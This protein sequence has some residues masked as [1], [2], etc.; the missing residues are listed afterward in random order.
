[1]S[2]IIGRKQIILAALVVALGAAIFLNWRFSVTG[3]K[4]QAT[5]ANE[6]GTAQYVST[7]SSA[8]NATDYFAQARLNR[9]KAQDAALE[10]L[11]GVTSSSGT[12]TTAKA[13]AVSGI[14]TLAK[15]IKTEGDIETLVLAKGF[16]DCIAVIG[17]NDINIIVKPKAKTD[18][19][20][21][22]SIQITDIVVSQTHCDAQKIKIITVK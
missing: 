8:A 1:M 6:Y 22:D 17:D 21:S 7:S 20:K 14:A 9:Q 13:Q 4:A 18:L 3:E 10:V 2:M 15:D 11:K 5:A 12:A 16:K 19:S